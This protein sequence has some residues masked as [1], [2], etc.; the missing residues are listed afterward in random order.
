MLAKVTAVEMT[1]DAGPGGVGVYTVAVAFENG[2]RAVFGQQF[3]VPPVAGQTWE[4]AE[5]R[6]EILKSHPDGSP[7]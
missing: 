3:A 2:G 1:Y 5:V 4:M 7:R 6:L